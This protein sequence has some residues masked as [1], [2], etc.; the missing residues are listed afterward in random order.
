[1][2]KIV[3]AMARG[4]CAADGY[5]WVDEFGDQWRKKAQAALTAA[6][7]AGFVFV[8]VE[9]TEAMWEAG[10][11]EMRNPSGL[12]RAYRAMIEEATNAGK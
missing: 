10:A 5:A 8:P 7:E 1:M 2:D 11:Q 12:I 3:E 4:L 9:P 6:R